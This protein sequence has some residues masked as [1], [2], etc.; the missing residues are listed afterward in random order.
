MR[1]YYLFIL[2]V[3]FAAGSTP[4]VMALPSYARQTGLPCS[5]CHYTPPELNPAGRLFK[6]MGYID[7]AANTSI[8]VTG[9]SRRAPL[10]MLKTLPLSAWLEASVTNLN[11]PQPGSQNGTAEFP[12]DVSLFLSGAWTSHVGSFL[13]VTYDVQDDH[14]SIDNT[15]VR[16]ANRKMLGQK[17]LDWGIT[18]NNNPTVEDL[19]NTTPAWGFPFILSDSAPGPAASPLLNGGLGQ[20]VAGI[21]A[22]AMYNQ[23]LYAAGTIYRSDHVG[24]PQPNAG[25]GAGVNISGVAP[26]WRVA[27]QETGR[28][29]NLEVGAYGMHV[30]SI[31]NAVTGPKD[32]YTDFGPDAQYD[33]TIGRD[34]LSVRGSYLRENSDLVGS[35]AG[36]SVSQAQHHLNEANAN[37]EYHIGNRYAGALGWFSTTGT[38]DPVL[39]APAAVSGSAN[40]SPKSRG[41]IAYLSYWPAQNLELAAQYTAYTSFNGASTNY[42]GSGRDASGNNTLYF[43][44]RFVF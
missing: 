27:W 7:R 17:E 37:V 18:L 36:G 1:R 23:H 28:T 5:G 30:S 16:Y 8:I 34:V 19:W 13:Q 20:D 22:F 29:N 10:D 25:I 6:L 39:Y 3:L 31:P 26:Y 24:S 35:L 43:L 2:C 41:L 14:F 40:G 15:D 12:Q 21:G 32:S 42:D 11:S 9:D 4:S 44:T 38:A 33:R